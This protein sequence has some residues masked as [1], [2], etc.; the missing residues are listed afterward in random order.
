M[1]KINMR[2]CCLIVS[3]FF[4][5]LFK[6]WSIWGLM[7][8]SLKYVFLLVSIFFALLNLFRKK[9]TKKAM[10]S[11]LLFG[12]LSKLIKKSSNSSWEKS[13]PINFGF[14]TSKTLL[15]ALL[16]LLPKF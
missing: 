3:V 9:Y 13:L 8:D 5:L 4:A 15:I 12:V 1:G 7:D 10:Q 6:Y 14:I 11:I 16:T 2:N